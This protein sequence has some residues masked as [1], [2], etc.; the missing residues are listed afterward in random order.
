MKRILT[1]AAVT[2]VA[3][4]A[5]P[6]L[7]QAAMPQTP[8]PASPVVEWN[9]FLLDLQATPGVQPATIHPTYELAIM[10]AA[11]YDAVVAIDRSGP[12][13]LLRIPAPRG[14]SAAAAA[15]TAAHDTLVALYPSQKPAIDREYAD[16]LDQLAGGRSRALGVRVGAI[17]AAAILQTRAHDGSAAPPVPFTPGSQPGDYQLTPPAF[18]QPVFTQWPGVR[19]F[20]LRRAS[21]FRP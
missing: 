21:E 20:A 2:C 4:A 17:A 12:P 1:A 10:H 18:A 14:A 15:D 7:S 8:R 5:L 6:A 16:T 11:I 19:P 9:R 3:L 13:Y